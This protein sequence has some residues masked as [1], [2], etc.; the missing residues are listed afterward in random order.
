MAEQRKLVQ[1]LAEVMKEV[2]YIQKRGYN[3]F[4]KYKY[5]TEADVAEKVREA[6]AE[7]NIVMI[8]SLTNHSIREHTTSKGNREYITTVV[9]EFRFI[10]GE[11]GETITFSMIGEGQDAGDKGPYKAMT[12]AQKYALMKTFMIPTGDDPEADEDVDKRNNE[13]QKDRQPSSNILA[14]LRAKWQMGKGSLD[15]FEEWYKTQKAQG[16]TEAQMDAYL[17]KALKKKGEESA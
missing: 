2:K 6:L 12:G 14:T 4:H 13:E 17:T 16:F 1:K 15:G 3:S 5:A 10:D 8:P 9:M 7:R 11:T